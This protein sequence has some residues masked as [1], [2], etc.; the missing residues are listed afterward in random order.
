MFLQ[1]FG[2]ANVDV[3]LVETIT[4]Y[5][6]TRLTS[7]HSNDRVHPP[8]TVYHEDKPYAKNHRP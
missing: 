2:V 7:R 3:R 5:P 6:S 8:T 1:L 4:T